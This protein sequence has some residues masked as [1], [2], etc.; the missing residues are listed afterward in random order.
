MPTRE[1]H[2]R[3]EKG[4]RLVPVTTAAKG[5]VAGERNVGTDDIL[6]TRGRLPKLYRERSYADVFKKVSN[7][8][9]SQIYRH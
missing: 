4:D 5:V 3:F 2:Q 1:A 8:V 7:D 9:A 6:P